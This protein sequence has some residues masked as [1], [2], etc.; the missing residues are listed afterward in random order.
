ML[1]RSYDLNILFYSNLKHTGDNELHNQADSVRY[2]YV[3]T[4]RLLTVYVPTKRLLTVYVPTKRLLSVNVHLNA[5]CLECF[6]T[7]PKFTPRAIDAFSAT[8]NRI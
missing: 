4:K 3:P 6:E 7:P 2:L 1:G 8:S 5:F